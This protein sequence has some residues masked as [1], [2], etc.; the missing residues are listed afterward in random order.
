MTT[1]RLTRGLKELNELVIPQRTND[2]D[3][4]YARED[5]G[6]TFVITPT[7]TRV[8]K[9]ETTGIEAGE[10]IAFVNLAATEKIT[11]DASGGGDIAT[12]Q[13]GYMELMAKQD[14]PT[15]AAHWMIIA[16][17]GGAKPV[18]SA[19]RSADVSITHNTL[20]RID[21]NTEDIDTNANYDNSTNFNFIP[22]VPGI[23]RFTVSIEF[24]G[25]PAD[26]YQRLLGYIYKNGAILKRNE[27]IWVPVTAAVTNNVPVI[28]E[29]RANGIDDDYEI[30]ITHVNSTSSDRSVAGGSENETHFGGN[31]IAA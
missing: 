9:L 1:N 12:F 17:G 26:T 18:F 7:A 3:R 28:Y 29:D 8:Q 10:V 5:M 2:A 21:F 6:K 23:Y 27:M 4:T 14:E 15:T 24:D 20:T 22:T 16:N 13:D 31:W 30:R 25:N 11:I 19:H